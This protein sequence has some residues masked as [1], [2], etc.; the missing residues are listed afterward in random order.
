MATEE[1]GKNELPPLDSLV[2][3]TVTKIMPYGAFCRMDEYDGREAFIHVSE[4]ASRW[5]K[6]IHEFIKE[7]QKVVARV[8][9]IVAEKDQ[10][11]LSLRRV[12]EADKKLKMEEFKREKRAAKLFELAAKKT[13]TEIAAAH[14]TVGVVLLKKYE[15]FYSALEDI[16]FNEG[17]PLEELDIPAEWKTVLLELAIANIHKP[18]VVIR[19][20]ATLQSFAPEGVEVLKAAL[21]DA[22]ALG[23]EANP[24]AVHY[25]GAPAYRVSVTAADY[26]TA[27]KLLDEANAAL[28]RRLKG[29]G[30]ATFAKEAA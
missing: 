18:Q 8:H 28:S 15:D 3:A 22:L 5:V 29:A 20:V 16:S 24:I 4:V 12:T 13:K 23:T 10:V 9:R 17:R 19:E 14:A 25:L 2:I 7:G 6:N 11:D 30:S 27:E 1:H 21:A 26:K